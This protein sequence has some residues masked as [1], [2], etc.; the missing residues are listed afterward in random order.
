MID[1][2]KQNVLAKCKNAIAGRQIDISGVV[3]SI[4]D[5]MVPNVEDSLRAVFDV[6]LVQ[7][8][9]P[10]APASLRLEILAFARTERRSFERK[11]VAIM[12]EHGIRSE[13]EIFTGCIRRYHS[14]NQRRQFETSQDVLRRS[15]DICDEYRDKFFRKVLEFHVEF[16]STTVPNTGAPSVEAGQDLEHVKSTVLAENC[17]DENWYSMSQIGKL[18][19]AA[20]YIVTYDPSAR[21]NGDPDKGQVLFGFP[22]IV[23]DV[24]QK[25]RNSKLGQQKG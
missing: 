19:A 2:S 3:L 7:C 21:W 14:M 16:S 24:L 8:F 6:S 5:E 4:V 12:N 11:I 1:R 20:Y 23:A 22:W 18:M 25:N 10:E 17:L 9:D 13:G 15:G